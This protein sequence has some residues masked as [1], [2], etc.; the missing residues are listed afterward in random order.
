MVQ[1]ILLII[2]LLTVSCNLFSQSN[3]L[4][5]SL[6][7]NI[8]SM[9][10]DT[11]KVDYLINLCW[12]LRN[13]EPGL[14]IIYGIEA[15]KISTDVNYK[16]GLVR[17]TGLL[18]VAYRNI[19]DFKNALTFFYEALYLAKEQQDSTELG[20]TYINFGS[21]YNTLEYYNDANK[22]LTDALQIAKKLSNKR[23]EAYVYYNLGVMYL[24]K[25]EFNIAK[26]NFRK[27]LQIRIE[28]QDTE[29]Q[30]S[31]YKYIG[32]SYSE[33]DSLQ[34]A[35][36]NY[37][38]AKELIKFDV[39]KDLV[40]DLYNQIGVVYYKRKMLDSAMYY[41]RISLQKAY[42]INSKL[43]LRDVY[44]NLSKIYEK[45]G[46][47]DSAYICHKEYINYHDSLINQEL[48]QKITYEKYR[49]TEYELKLSEKENENNQLKIHKQRN[50]LILS[51]IIISIVFLMV[52][53]L[54]KSNSDKR[55]ANKLLNLKNEEIIKQRDEIQI[56]KNIAIE[57]KEEIALKNEE[58]FAQNEEIIKQRD[59]IFEQKKNISDSIAYACRIQEAVLYS[60]VQLN[61]LFTDAFI[62]FRPRDIVSGDFYWYRQ[63][64]DNIIVTAADCTGH[65][66]PGAFMS[67]LGIS[68]LEEIVFSKNITMPNQILEKLRQM[69]KASLKQSL[70]AFDSQD[71]M[72]M[73]LCSF[74]K[75]TKKMYF[76]GANNPAILIRNK[77][78]Q[79]LEAN[80]NPVG[81][82]LVEKPFA[83]TEIDYF[84]NDLV[85]LFSDG[86]S[87]QFSPK[88]EKFKIARFKKLLTEVS[89]K[90]MKEQMKIINNTFVD[91]KGSFRQIDDILIIGIKL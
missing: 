56:Q 72:D 49:T 13:S 70:E 10:P 69:I 26:L 75:K 83:Q 86:F 80:F 88:R 90:E 59:E 58:L 33:T 54:M 4:I 61:E 48:S 53:I 68:A 18:G 40:S 14:S 30:A 28:I 20:F 32:N 57:Q 6:N 67:M 82:D 36:S 45:K 64:D 27:A 51:I 42:E 43:R 77:E 31:C 19:G 5:D 38:K 65:G 3:K 29:G 74:D 8:E 11:A 50:Q 25:N 22:N 81:I 44:I 34:S 15:I 62:Y 2:F 24:S 52:F 87:D 85:Y 63:V 17:A 84:D 78:L 41:F 73:A 60:K 71:G 7:Y 79:I 16:S 21:L 55:K 9:K 66:V 46:N 37:Q 1:K 76:S 23:M 12:N 35:F 89:E 91:W 39:D 47:I